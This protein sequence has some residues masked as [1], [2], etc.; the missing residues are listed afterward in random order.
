M[1]LD[2]AIGKHTEWKAKF[3][4]AISKK[5][6]MDAKTISKDD[7]CDLGKWLHGE[8]KAKLATF[9]SYSECMN[10]HAEFHVEAGKLARAINAKQY[11]KAEAM[12]GT[13]T[14]YA[15]VS[16]AVVVAIMRLKKEAGL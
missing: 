9:A 3:R 1:D 10:K 12:L 16:S 2:Q 15:E 7:C 8:A 6:P 4:L 13:G 5:E 14:P 11:A